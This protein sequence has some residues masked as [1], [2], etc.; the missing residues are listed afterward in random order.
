VLIFEELTIGGVTFKNLP[1]LITDLPGPDV[2]LGQA[3]LQNLNLHFAFG[4]GRVYVSDVKRWAWER[5]LPAGSCG[6]SGAPRAG[7]MPALPGGRLL[8]N[9][10]ALRS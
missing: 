7:K 10:S 3:Q 6:S 2:T 1:T 9:L 5:R 8:Q 4:E